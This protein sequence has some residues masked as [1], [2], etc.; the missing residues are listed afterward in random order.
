MKVY[1]EQVCNPKCIEIFKQIKQLIDSV[2]TFPV[3][4]EHDVSCHELCYAIKEIYPTQLRIETG[5]FLPRFKHSWLRTLPQG[6]PTPYDNLIDVYPVGM[7][8][9][10]MLIENTIV[11]SFRDSGL[12]EVKA[13]PN[14]NFSDKEFQNIVRIIRHTL[15]QK[16]SGRM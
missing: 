8:G 10:P 12:Y 3:P 14:L 15:V 5:Y 11:R 2:D 9:G 13:I 7:I 6:E 1:A 4:A 16:S